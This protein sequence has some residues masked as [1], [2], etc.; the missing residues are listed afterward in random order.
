MMRA[1]TR[2]ATDVHAPG[3]RRPAATRAAIQTTITPRVTRC[4]TLSSA[5]TSR[6]RQARCVH[7]RDIPAER[8]SRSVSFFPKSVSIVDRDTLSEL[9][10]LVQAFGDEGEP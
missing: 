5:L 8:V 4:S 7:D 6:S 10:Q 9:A 1:S 3:R 2:D